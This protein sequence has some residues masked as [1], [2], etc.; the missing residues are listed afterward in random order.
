[1]LSGEEMIYKATVVICGK[2]HAV[3]V[4]NGIR[5]ID[6]MTVDEFLKTLDPLTII[7]FANVGI[8]KV[9][10]VVAGKKIHNYQGMMDH[11]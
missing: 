11:F 4:R 6:D 2:K 1:M 8:A 9:H 5:Y 3:E 10:D 7:D